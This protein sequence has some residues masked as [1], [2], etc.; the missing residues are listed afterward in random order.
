MCTVIHWFY[1]FPQIL[2]FHSA[3]PGEYG[4]SK[5]VDVAMW[6]H[7]RDYHHKHPLKEVGNFVI[8]D[9]LL[10][11]DFDA[12][13]RKKISPPYTNYLESNELL[14]FWRAL[15]TVRKFGHNYITLTS[16]EVDE[17]CEWLLNMRERFEVEGVGIFAE[18]HM[19]DTQMTQDDSDNT[20]HKENPTYESGGDSS[21]CMIVSEECSNVQTQEKTAAEADK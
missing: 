11:Q 10:H 2:E 15:P 9:E 5:D 20:N 13:K 21:N 1:D 3:K 12:F 6:L 7:F 18:T 19:P 14:S 8:V 16:G 17:L 4:L